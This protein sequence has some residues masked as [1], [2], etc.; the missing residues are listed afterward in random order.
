MSGKRDPKG[1]YEYAEMFKRS[2]RALMTLANIMEEEM[3]D[4]LI[5]KQ[6][7]IQ[8]P[9]HTGDGYRAI[10]KG[11]AAGNKFVGFQNADTPENVLSQVVAKIANGTLNW[12]EDTPWDGGIKRAGSGGGLDV[13]R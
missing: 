1:D 8:G 9:T 6:I 2:W 12:K 3:A 7:T 4:G 5:V 10:V 13:Q 11:Q